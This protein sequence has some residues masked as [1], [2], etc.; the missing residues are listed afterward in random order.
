MEMFTLNVAMVYQTFLGNRQKYSHKERVLKFMLNL[1]FFPNLE[2]GRN[3]SLF[4]LFSMLLMSLK[5]MQRISA[6][7]HWVS[8][9]SKLFDHS[10][11]NF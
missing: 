3:N 7:L 11:V 9:L 2:K 5:N 6:C 1:L 10:F 4:L 8:V